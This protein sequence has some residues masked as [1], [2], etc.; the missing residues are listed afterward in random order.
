MSE[1]TPEQMAALH[2]FV[3]AD[4]QAS[5]AL[6]APPEFARRFQPEARRFGSMR[7]SMIAELD[8]AFFNRI[9]GLGMGEPAT[10]AMLDQAITCLQETGCQNYMA[11]VSPL[12]QPAQFP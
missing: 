8:S 4:A 9:L 7:V 1:M 5:F 10:E 2:E 6:C 12:A 11:Q 3:E